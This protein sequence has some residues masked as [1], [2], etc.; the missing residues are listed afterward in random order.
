MSVD[1][2]WGAIWARFDPQQPARDR[3]LVP[4]RYSPAEQAVEH[5]RRNAGKKKLMVVGTVGSGKSTELLHVAERT[6]EFATPIFFDVEH[7]FTEIVHDPA[8]LQQVAPWEVLFLVGLAVLRA[9]EHRFATLGPAVD[10]TRVEAFS[11]AAASLFPA[12][13]ARG[14]AAALSLSDLIR[15][16]LSRTL[17]VFVGPG[18][19]A[20]APA[21]EVAQAAAD[22]MNW[23]VELGR[24]HVTVGDQ[25]RRVHALLGAV[26]GL[27]DDVTRLFK[28]PLILFID[29]LDKIGVQETNEGLFIQSSVLG[30]L[31]VPTVVTGSVTFRHSALANR[32]SRFHRL[33]V[34][35]V[36]VF[37]RARPHERGGDQAF[38]LEL[39]RKR[40]EHIDKAPLAIP[41]W[42]LLELAYYSGG[43]V[44]D[45][46]HLVQEVA[47]QAEGAGRAVADKA[48]IAAAVAD[49]RRLME[50]GFSGDM[51]TALEMVIQKPDELPGAPV[52]QGVLF[53]LLDNYQLLPYPNESEWWYPHTLLDRKLKFSTTS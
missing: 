16:G 22:A 13:E 7:H 52:D 18:P 27:L 24:S 10:P 30:Q 45:F 2:L 28:R 26:N 19:D 48:V 15:K 41:E 11:D 25:D 17:S 33:D 23:E 3:L 20:I 36:P 43:R 21:L 42:G 6:Q 50:S 44:R 38:F 5:L 53:R 9:A 39:Y 31:S 40:V 32:L 37:S 12:A 47:F 8:A 1:A 4:R 29:G 49:R 35:N 34:S 46:M 51:R 14:G